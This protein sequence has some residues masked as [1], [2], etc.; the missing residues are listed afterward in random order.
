[1]AV[2]PDEITV[3]ADV[4]MAVLPEEVRAVEEVTDKGNLVT[5]ALQ[6][7]EGMVEG[8]MLTIPEDILMASITEKRRPWR[9]PHRRRV[10]RTR[11]TETNLDSVLRSSG[12]PGRGDGRHINRRR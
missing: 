10:D 7:R 2:K 11:L 12:R 3:S 6:E 8:E 5:S 9:S 4:D 1:M